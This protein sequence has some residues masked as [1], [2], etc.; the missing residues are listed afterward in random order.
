MSENESEESALEEFSRTGRRILIVMGLLVLVVAGGGLVV[1]MTVGPLEAVAY[2][3]L[4]S[5]LVG[6]IFPRLI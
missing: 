3:V 4:M 2:V 6:F 1:G 5:A